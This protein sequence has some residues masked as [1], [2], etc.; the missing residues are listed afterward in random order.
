MSAAERVLDQ[1]GRVIGAIDPA[2]HDRIEGW[3]SI[4]DALQVSERTAKR[5]ADPGSQFR[6]PIRENHRGVYITRWN[7]QRW[8][9]DY[10][11]AWAGPGARA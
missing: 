7:L 1:Q 2:P 4:A 11:R 9:E 8:L 3:K 10:D 5:L 6:L